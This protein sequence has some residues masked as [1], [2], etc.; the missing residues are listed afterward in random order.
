M[1]VS[2]GIP[3]DPKARPYYPEL[4]Q[5]HEVIIYEREEFRR[6]FTGMKGYIEISS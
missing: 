1:R 6:N 3:H 5:D 2:Q 4:F